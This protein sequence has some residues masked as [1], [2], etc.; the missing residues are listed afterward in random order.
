MIVNSKSDYKVTKKSLYLVSTPIGNL[1]DISFRAIDILKKS[2][3]ILCEDT[4]VSKNLLN[5]YQIQSKL[6]SN[7]KFNEKKNLSK[8]I[9]FIKQGLFVSLISDAGT[10]SIS[11]PGAI[12]IK[13]CI[14]NNIE[15]VPLPGATAVTTA[16]SISGFSEKFFFYGFFPEKN[17]DLLNDLEI[18][19]QLNSSLVFFISSKKLNKA[20]PVIKQNF[21]GREIMIC[22]EMTKFYEEYLRYKVEDL[23]IFAE[24]LKGEL[25]I[26]L[27]EKKRVKKGSLFLSESDKKDIKKMI[28]KLSIKEIT[29]LISRNNNI[30]KKEI[31][32]YC[33]KVKNEN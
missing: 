12:L 31:Y 10:P 30:P 27:S 3:Y 4:R 15:I 18:I 26:V 1:N 7:H 11:D 9:E 14:K 19:S 28:K 16:L 2:D 29:N 17:K 13:E 25:T 33:V 6:I 23:K 22:R 24:T 32:N 21:S 20:I 8:I 5:K